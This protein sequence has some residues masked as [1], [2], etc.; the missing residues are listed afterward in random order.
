MVTGAPQRLAFL[1]LVGLAL[2]AESAG[3]S[4]HPEPAPQLSLSITPSRGAP[5]LQVSLQWTVESGP[6]T[7]LHCTVD[8]GDD[9]GAPAVREPCP[10]IGSAEHTYT[11]LGTFAPTV[12]VVAHHGGSGRSE[13]TVVVE[14][15]VTDLSI[16]RVEWGQTVFSTEPRLVAQKEALLRV[17]VVSTDAGIGPIAVRAVGSVD[18]GSLGT[19]ELVGPPIVPNAPVAEDVTQSFIA[20]VPPEWITPGLQ[21][22]IRIDADDAVSESNEQNNTASLHP[23]VGAGN[24][25]PLTLVPVVQQGLQPRDL[26][27]PWFTT[28]WRY[29]P[30]TQVLE[31]VR[32][33]YTFDGALDAQDVST[34]Q[35]LL[36]QIDALRTTDQSTEWYYGY[37]QVNY[38]AGLAGLGLVGQPAAVGRDDTE[39]ALTHELGHTFNLLHAPCG[40]ASNPDPN[41]PHPGAEIGVWGWDLVFH[42]LVHPDTSLDI[43]S[44]CNPAWV[45][46]YSYARAQAHLEATAPTFAGASSTDAFLVHGHIEPSGE[47]VFQ[48]VQRVNAVPSPPAAAAGGW[49]VRLETPLGPI[50]VEPRLAQ[51]AD[52]GAVRFSAVV[53]SAGAPTL[54][55]LFEGSRELGRLR[56]ETRPAARFVPRVSAAEG[57]W[58]VEW[59]ADATPAL[60]VAHVGTRRTTLALSLRGGRAFVPSAGLP[61]GGELELSASDG[62]SAQSHRIERPELQRAK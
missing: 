52:T 28:L 21:V 60:A 41:Y 38:S 59:D 17:H 36:D 47:V 49:R 62:V 34:W 43:M 27:D 30:L 16:A 3:C 6:G 15:A 2:F 5:P 22:D 32:T 57:G 9:S 8:F 58:L 37:A 7:T 19:L 23:V 11:S 42:R 13:A 54:V 18:G 4:G 39:R 48:P 46:D 24:L 55:S 56:R 44:Y 1:A 45:S 50:E 26:L 51:V 31:H 53:P 40:G 20:T 33:P 12:T 14:P 61:T 25:L 29:W 35:A 10:R